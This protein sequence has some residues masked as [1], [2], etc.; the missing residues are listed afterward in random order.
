MI[1]K[2]IKNESEHTEALKRLSALMDAQ[3]GTPDG[4]EL[5]LLAML[6][7]AYERE[8]YPLPPPDPVEAIKFRM[9]Q[10]NLKKKDLI[11]YIGNLEKVSE[12]LNRKRPLTLKMIRALHN[13]L[14]IPA[15]SL[16]AEATEK[17]TPARMRRTREM[18]TA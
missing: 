10:A 7:E 5:A 6:I 2:L 15:E 18:R 14:G 8:R 12:V 11:P 17:R 4:D 3:P 9:D 13:G 1:L 16:L